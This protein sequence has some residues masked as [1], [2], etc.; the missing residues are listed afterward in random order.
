MVSARPPSSFDLV[1]RSAQVRGHL[2]YGAVSYSV[3]LGPEAGCQRFAIGGGLD[4]SF[5]KSPF[6]AG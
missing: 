3:A 2:G 6:H 4:F 1:G 5:R